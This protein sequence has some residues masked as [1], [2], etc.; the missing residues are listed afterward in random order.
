MKPPIISIV[1]L[2]GSG[3]TTLLERLIRELKWRG[4]S[5]G[6]IKHSSHPHPMDMPGKD[7]WRHK[8][9][10]AVRTLFVGPTTLQYVADVEDE[11]TPATLAKSYMSGLDLVLVEGFL[12]EE[13]DKIEVVRSERSDKPICRPQSGADGIGG[14]IAVMSDLDSEALGGPGVDVLDVDDVDGLANLIMERF[15][16]KGK[17]QDGASESGP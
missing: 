13:G 4:L 6:T 10:G 16:L 15:S 5:V 1:G 17:Q 2:S 7:S 3:K 14:L 12:T 11:P 8:K 9:A